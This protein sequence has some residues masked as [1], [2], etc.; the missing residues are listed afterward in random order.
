M[1][2]IACIILQSVF[3][4]N[5]VN[6]VEK[7]FKFHWIQLVCNNWRI[8]KSLPTVKSLPDFTFTSHRAVRFY[9]KIHVDN[10]ILLG[11]IP[12]K[13]YSTVALK[14]CFV[15]LT[16][17]RVILICLSAC[18]SK[19]LWVAVCRERLSWRDKCNTFISPYC[20][21]YD[22]GMFKSLTG[23]FCLNFRHEF[24][25][26]SDQEWSSYSL[27]PEKPYP[28]ERGFGLKI[29]LEFRGRNVLDSHSADN[30]GMCTAGW[31]C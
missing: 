22:L 28:C 19:I 4:C 13:K 21:C 2:P 31:C 8:W 18:I 16:R 11:R 6:S 9:F 10:I 17:G 27:T 12:R 20:L 1:F 15:L 3:S 14:S 24:G 26:G 29:L 30:Q 23:I 25:S 5:S 7:V